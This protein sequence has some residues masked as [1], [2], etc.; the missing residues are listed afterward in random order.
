MTEAGGRIRLA[1]DVQVKHH[2]AWTLWG[3]LRSDLLD[4]G[5]P[6]TLL[7]LEKE[8]VQ[9]DLNMEYRARLSVVLALLMILGLVLAPIWPRTLILCLGSGLVLLWLNLGFYRLLARQGG[10]ALLIGGMVMHWLYQLNCA[11]AYLTGR[12]LFWRR[13]E[14]DQL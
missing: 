3:V 7:L 13:G 14:V 4:R 9:K 10:A 5:I 1:R 11:A 2:K 6:W 8:Q 12:V